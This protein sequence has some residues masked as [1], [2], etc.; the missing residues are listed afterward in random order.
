MA[1]YEQIEVM[2]SMDKRS[3]AQK[4]TV[5]GESSAKVVAQA[6][7]PCR[8]F[9]TRKRS[10]VGNPFYD[11]RSLTHDEAGKKFDHLLWDEW[12]ARQAMPVNAQ[13]W[14]WARV[15]EYKAGKEIDLVCDCRIFNPERAGSMFSPSQE[16]TCHGDSLKA[17]I[18][19][20][21]DSLSQ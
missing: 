16:K 21:A 1:K 15:D 4:T 17:Y 18:I 2:G 13:K 12:H 10:P 11:D 19:F 14:F 8:H 20:L 5:D 3:V 7:P 9:I 6:N